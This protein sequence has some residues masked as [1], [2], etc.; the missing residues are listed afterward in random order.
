MLDPDGPSKKDTSDIGHPGDCS[1]LAHGLRASSRS[2]ASVEAYP[3]PSRPGLRCGSAEP[4][5][6]HLF[7]HPRRAD[8]PR[9]VVRLGAL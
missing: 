5:A 9:R 6:Q 4:T 1:H 3:Q 2:A 7:H 8:L